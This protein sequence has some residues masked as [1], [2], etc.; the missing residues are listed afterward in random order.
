MLKEV[1]LAIV[2]G[3]LLAGPAVAQTV[4]VPLSD[5]ATPAL[6]VKH[7]GKHDN[8]RHLGWYKHRGQDADANDDNNDNRRR[9]NRSTT[10]PYRYAPPGYYTPPAYGSSYPP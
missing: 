10:T 7:D 4:R 1:G 5:R 3:G 9:R 2:L 6:L 8:G